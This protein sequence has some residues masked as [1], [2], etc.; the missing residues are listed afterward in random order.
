MNRHNYWRKEIGH[1][2]FEAETPAGK[3]FDIALLWF[4]VISIIAVMLESVTSIRLKYGMALRALEWVFTFAFTLEYII[5]IY[6]ARKPWRYILSFFGLVDLIAILPSYL[7]LFI[8]GSQYLLVI[9]SL[10]LLRV[11]RVLKLVRYLGEADILMR[12]LKSSRAKIIVF[13]GTVMT[14]VLIIGSFMYLIEG[15]VNG[16][17]SIPKSIYWAIVTLTTVGYGDISPKTPLGQVLASVVMILG[18]GVIAVPTGIVTVELSNISKQEKPFVKC[19]NCKPDD[20]DGDAL[21]CKYCA[22]SLKVLP[23][24]VFKK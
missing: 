8:V 12:A 22:S 6:V 4:I 24:A 23:E 1:I 15:E 7:S 16:F 9:R 18:Y 3:A 10:R 21:F 17:D 13:L 20:H 5:R 2:I 19:S 14:S 11:F